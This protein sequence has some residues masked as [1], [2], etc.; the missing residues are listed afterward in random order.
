MIKYILLLLGAINCNL[1]DNLF[2][3]L[4]SPQYALP[5]EFKM[6]LYNEGNNIIEILFS[7]YLNSIRIT[8]LENFIQKED[9]PIVDLYVNFTAGTASADFQDLCFY[10]NLTALQMISSRFILDSYDLFTYFKANKETKE[11]EY[12]ISNPLGNKLDNDFGFLLD[13]N[14]KK[15]ALI[16]SILGNDID[17]LAYVVFRVNMETEVLQAIDFKYQGIEYLNL[18]TKVSW[19]SSF[20][21]TLFQPKH[22]CTYFN[23]TDLTKSNN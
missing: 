8:L 2:S 4:D 18:E 19:V 21:K 13:D 9:K 10:R 16:K 7:G 15:S 3:N 11:Y 20:N 17:D 12:L 5:T 22:N 6:E 23:I 14:A 1:W